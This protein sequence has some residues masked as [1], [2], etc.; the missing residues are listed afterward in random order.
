M[1]LLAVAPG[2]QLHRDQIMGVCWPHAELPSALRNL[3]VAVHCA[4]HSLEPEL[5][6]RAVSSYLVADGPLFRLAADTVWIDADDAESRGERALASSGDTGELADALALFTGELL[7]EDQSAAWAEPRR[8]RLRI[9]CGE[10][11]LTLARIHLTAGETHRAMA[12]AR[13]VLETDAAAEQAHQLLVD[14]F[15]RTGHRDEAVRQYRRCAAALQ[16]IHG[17]TPGPETVRLYRT[18]LGTGRSAAHPARDIS[19]IRLDW[20]QA[21]ERSGRYSDAAGVL[22]EAIATFE[23]QGDGDACAVSGARL[24]G[25]LVRE[26]AADDARTALQ[27]CPPERSAG[28]DVQAEHHLAQAMLASYE[29]EYAAGLAAA[30]AAQHASSAAEGP[31]R[32]ALLSRSLAQQ[33]VCLGLLGFTEE[34]GGPAEEA[35]AAAERHGDPALLATVR[36]V[37]REN[38]RRAGRHREALLHGQRA[39]VLAEQAGRPTVTAFERANLAELHLL[40]GERYEAERLALAA[41]TLAEPFKG[42]ALAF[43]L[44]ALARVRTHPDPPGALALLER[45]E[46]CARAGGHHQALAEV[47]A[48]HTAW[49]ARHRPG[50][51]TGRLA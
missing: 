26:G 35:L 13:R 2:R 34:A 32:R 39:L 5:A 29:G 47:R 40:L 37:L 28:A 27:A 45:A 25:V 17:T 24:A 46:R 43:A 7:P 23:Q 15:V 3:R 8:D 41:V 12:A 6:P 9:L 4:R 18:A 11:G 51:P 44:T 1:K 36:S 50:T 10:V 30:R 20:A 19:R 31:D 42:T 16:Q 48:A 14:A 21:L 22:R 38:A 33:A 49:A